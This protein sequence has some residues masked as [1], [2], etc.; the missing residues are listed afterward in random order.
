MF[1]LFNILETNYWLS[2]FIGNSVGATVSYF[3]NKRFTFK[4]MQTMDRPFEVHLYYIDMLYTVVLSQLSNQSLPDLK[5][6]H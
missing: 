2:T 4:M 6:E 1:L 3:L 5:F